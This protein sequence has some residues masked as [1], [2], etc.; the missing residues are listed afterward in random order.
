MQKQSLESLNLVGFSVRTT[1]AAEMSQDTAQIASLW[2][3]FSTQVWPTLTSDSQV[4]GVYTNYESDYA[5]A[6]DVI[7]CTDSLNVNELEDT[8]VTTIE[9]GDYLTF[10]AQG[11]MPQ[12]VIDLWGEVWAYFSQPNC[13]HTRKYTSDFE[14]YIGED[15]VEISIAIV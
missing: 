15:Q 9:S 14:R 2:Q 5:G 7:A 3:K 11:E 10:K 1:N 8:V 6:F 12:A 4:F 13:P